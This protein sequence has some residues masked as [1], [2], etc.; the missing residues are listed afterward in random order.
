[1]LALILLSFPEQE[2]CHWL[3]AELFDALTHKLGHLN[4]S[5]F[6]NFISLLFFFFIIFK[7][8]Y[9]AYF[10]FGCAGS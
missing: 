9:F 6:L 4:S 3:C 10:L 8:I 1:M 7:N 2:E 5:L